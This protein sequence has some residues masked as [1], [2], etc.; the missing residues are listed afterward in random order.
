VISSVSVPLAFLSGLLSFVSPCV[1][2]LVPV[3]VGYLSGSGLSGKVLAT[4]RQLFSHAL[5]FVSGFTVVF[6]VVFGLP[7]TLLGAVF[8]R[9]GAWVS[10]A[11]GV[12]LILFGLH[13][14]GIITIPLF[15]VTRRLEVGRGMEP[16][17]LRSTLIGVSFAAGWTPCIGPL[18]GT[19]ITL[20]FTEPTR[21]IGLLFVYA[22]GL[23][24]PFVATA[25]LLTQTIGWL[26][27]LKRYVRAIQIASGLLMV[28]VGV[29]LISGTFTMLNGF[30]MRVTPGWMLE[31]M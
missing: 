15:N 16:G 17:Y 13:T 28:A 20:G 11:G 19:V 4:R 25:A 3:Y 22:L 18:L 10:K 23:A 14:L 8:A 31:H 7:M 12:V 21:A 5:F 1:L 30:L 2:P 27:R 6:V 26:N 29:L 9:F 24:V